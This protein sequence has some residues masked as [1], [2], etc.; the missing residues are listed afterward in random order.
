[1]KKTK[2]SAKVAVSVIVNPTIIPY[3]NSVSV[4]CK[5]VEEAE[6]FIAGRKL[7]ILSPARMQPRYDENGALTFNSWT[8][9]CKSSNPSFKKS[10]FVSYPAPMDS[11][12][13]DF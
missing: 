7:E 11:A 13:L 6:A 1:M 10:L 5:S 8:I 9:R 12:D 3:A 4:S 2:V